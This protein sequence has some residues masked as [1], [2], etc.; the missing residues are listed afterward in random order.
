MAITKIAQVTVGSGGAASIDLTSIPGTFTDIMLLTSLRSTGNSVVR[1]T[2]NS[3]GTTYAEKILQGD[4]GTASSFNE[5]NFAGHTVPST[6]TASTFDSKTIY[7]PNYAGSTAKTFSIDSVSENNASTAYQNLIAGS[8]NGTGAITSI[9][10][11]A[12]N[13]AEFS[14]VTLYGISKSGATGASVA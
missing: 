2:F 10:L 14:S 1:L 5:T 9:S 11:T 13:F 12:S 6:H 3:T 8:W 4:G 7:I